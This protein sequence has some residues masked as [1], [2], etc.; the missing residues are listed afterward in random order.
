MASLTALVPAQCAHYAHCAGLVADR[1][2][3]H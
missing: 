1:E 3:G 2:K